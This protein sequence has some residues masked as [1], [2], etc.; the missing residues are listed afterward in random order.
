MPEGRRSSSFR[1]RRVP[2][3]DGWGNDYDYRWSGNVLSSQVMGICSQA[4]DGCG[5]SGDAPVRR[6]G[7]EDPAGGRVNYDTSGSGA[8]CYYLRGQG[9]RNLSFRSV[10]PGSETWR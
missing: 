6:S 3:T 8:G 9:G 4:P 10:P 2:T 1:I 5:C 7:G